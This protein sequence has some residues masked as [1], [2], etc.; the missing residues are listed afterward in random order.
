MTRASVDG[1]EG[2]LDSTSASIFEFTLKRLLRR[3]LNERIH[4]KH[5]YIEK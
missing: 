1:R 5:T 3:R 2:Q 4:M